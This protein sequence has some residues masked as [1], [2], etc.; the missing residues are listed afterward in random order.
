M[1]GTSVRCVKLNSPSSGWR[2]LLFRRLR[3]TAPSR[4]SGHRIRVARWHG[5]GVAASP[6]FR[7]EPV[8]MTSRRTFILGVAAA[9]L[10]MPISAKARFAPL[11]DGNSLGGSAAAQRS[12]EKGDS[13]S[14]RHRMGLSTRRTRAIG[15]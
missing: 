4:R 2:F 10:A 9:S 6:L 14:L 8:I 3:G 13:R 15:A 1:T 12:V 7:P 5:C 11:F